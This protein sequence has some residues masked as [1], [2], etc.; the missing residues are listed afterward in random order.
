MC[1]CVCFPFT[2][3]GGFDCEAVKD[4][5]IKITTNKR[6]YQHKT[7]TASAFF[8]ASASTPKNSNVGG[9]ESKYTFLKPPAV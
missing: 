1:A 2:L 5:Y 9:N 3:C 4:F 8:S 6:L 7:Q